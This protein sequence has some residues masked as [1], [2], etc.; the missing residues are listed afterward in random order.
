M[1]APQRQAPSWHK[2][3]IGATGGRILE[4]DGNWMSVDPPDFRHLG[5][6]FQGNGYLSEALRHIEIPGV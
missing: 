6:F 2:H 1:C 3:N 5:D 4:V